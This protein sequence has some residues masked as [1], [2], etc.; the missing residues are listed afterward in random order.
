MQSV[1]QTEAGPD[2][3]LNGS[4]GWV[5]RVS[6]EKVEGWVRRIVEG[7]PERLSVVVDGKYTGDA[8]DV[9]EPLADRP[10]AFRFEILLAADF[11]PYSAVVV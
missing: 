1:H 5:D 8:A 6:R 9:A 3:S 10:G 2:A 4:Q 7:E 11:S